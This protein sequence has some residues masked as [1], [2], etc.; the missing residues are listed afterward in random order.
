MM[1][2]AMTGFASNAADLAGRIKDVLIC[3]LHVAELEWPHSSQ[4][5]SR[6]SASNAKANT[7]TAFAL[8][9]AMMTSATRAQ[10]GKG[11]ERS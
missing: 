8:S 9:V 5:Q 1:S 4:P 7:V 10:R 2:W 3:V 11:R 6:A